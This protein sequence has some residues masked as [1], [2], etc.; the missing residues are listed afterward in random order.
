MTLRV[1]IFTA[2]LVP[3]LAFAQ[4]AP[5]AQPFQRLDGCAYKPQRWDDG[6]SFHVILPDQKELI[7]R[8]YFVDTPEEERV[9]ADRIAE[10]AAYFGI[11]PD[12]AIQIGREAS[13][14]TK[15]AL[16][17]P[18]TIYTQPR[19]CLR[20]PFVENGA[21]SFAIEPQTESILR[22]KLRNLC[23][24]IFL[25]Q[26]PKAF[27][28]PLVNRAVLPLAVHLAFDLSRQRFHCFAI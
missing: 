25:I 19:L 21:H 11:T 26:W 6:D 3:L 22:C 24:P 18:F 5:P 4:T 2:L 10:Q 13:E 17:K 15:Q 9:Y 16:T 27:Q 7:F 8:L 23:L 20:G 12:A 28:V 1:S 14:F